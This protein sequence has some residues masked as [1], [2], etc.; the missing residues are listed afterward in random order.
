MVNN[1]NNKKNKKSSE[2]ML[3]YITTK[4]LVRYGAVPSYL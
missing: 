1:N 4:F 3:D 2:Y